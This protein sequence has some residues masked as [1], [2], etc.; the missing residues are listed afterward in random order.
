MDGSDLAAYKRRMLSE[1]GRPDGATLDVLIREILANDHKYPHITPDDVRAA[2]IR[3]R[4]TKFRGTP[5]PLTTAE[6]LA[7]LR[8]NV[9]N[10]SS[11]AV[12]R[13]QNQGRN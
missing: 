6:K 8:R 9:G 13:P 7:R 3:N 2:W 1:V 12:Q 10:D 5:E 4:R 11:V